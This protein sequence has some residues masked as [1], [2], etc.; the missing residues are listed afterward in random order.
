MPSPAVFMACR[1][2]V[3]ARFLYQNYLLLAVFSLA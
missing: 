2:E 1:G 3:M